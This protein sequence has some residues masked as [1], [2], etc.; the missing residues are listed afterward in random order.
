MSC[1]EVKL[2]S[3]F[4]SP[5]TF[6]QALAN[7]EDAIANKRDIDTLTLLQLIREIYKLKSIIE[8]TKKDDNT[9]N[10]SGS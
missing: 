8:L 5:M 9:G 6:E 4:T 7:A 3:R 10:R 1:G 2:M